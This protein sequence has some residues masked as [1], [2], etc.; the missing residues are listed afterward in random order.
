MMRA[1]S[2]AQKSVYIEMYIFLADTASTHDFVCVL[3]QKA[4]A[5]LEV[6]IV[7][8]YFG[9]FDLKNKDIDELRA[10]GVEFLF[11]SHWLRRTHRKFVIID[12]RIAF[13]GG[14]NIKEKT[15]NWHDLNMQVSG[16]IVKP[17]IKSFAYTYKMA[18]GKKKHILAYRGRSFPQKVKSWLIDN[19]SSTKKIYYLNHYYRQSIINAK[20]LIQIVT[21]Y[22]LPPRWLI[23]VLD[24]AARRGVRIE[25]IIP[26]QTDAVFLDKINYLNAC[27]LSALGVNFYFFPG[28]NHAKAMLVDNEE[29]IVGSQNMDILSFG[30]N[31]EAGAFFRQKDLV[32]DLSKIIEAWKKHS[33]SFAKTRPIMKW[34]DRFLVFIFKIFYP[35]F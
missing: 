1:I 30:L 24:G 29:G 31:I 21:P 18:G 33:L 4:L 7:A 26:S 16:T 14:V 10:A 17:I 23:A 32:T 5:G 13:L 27:R 15:R 28:M 34:G 20:S 25:F 9:S 2:G 22:L 6:V 8:D 19:W 3:K 11:F 12:G 35:I